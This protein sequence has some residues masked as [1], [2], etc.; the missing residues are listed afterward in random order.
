MS[1]SATDTEHSLATVRSLQD[2]VRAEQRRPLIGSSAAGVAGDE[3]GLRGAGALTSSA[4]CLKLEARPAGGHRPAQTGDADFRLS[5]QMRHRLASLAKAG[6]AH[7]RTWTE[8]DVRHF[9]QSAVSGA[10]RLHAEAVTKAG[11]RLRDLLRMCRQC[12]VLIFLSH[13]DVS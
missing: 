10:A 5:L 3:D 13:L 12:S 9:V 1:P 6:E 7:P 8:K 4:F 11:C 2:P